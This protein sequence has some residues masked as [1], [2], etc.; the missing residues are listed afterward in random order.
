VVVAGYSEPSLVFLLGTRT[1]LAS[2]PAAAAILS[3]LPDTLALVSDREDATF[4]TALAQSGVSADA[5]GT[6]SGLNYSNGRAV[7]LTLYE[8]AR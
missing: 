7:T 5:L 1:K 6:V 2:A 3:K 4:R 8:T